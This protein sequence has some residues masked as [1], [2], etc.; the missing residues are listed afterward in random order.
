[1]DQ[2]DGQNFGAGCTAAP[3]SAAA[4]RHA[5]EG[6]DADRRQNNHDLENRAP[7]N[8]SHQS[9]VD[10]AGSSFECP[11]AAISG[12]SSAGK[13]RLLRSANSSLHRLMS[14]GDDS[15][16]LLLQLC[17]HF[18]NDV[19]R[20]ASAERIGRLVLHPGP[21]GERGSFKR[22]IL[23]QSSRGRI[24]CRAGRH[25]S[26]VGFARILIRL[27]NVLHELCLLALSRKNSLAQARTIRLVRLVAHR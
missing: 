2:N 8:R 27:H 16:D 25:V 15:I 21:L 1:M 11:R 7:K 13:I 26:P 3:A 6:N 4:N 19:V 12:A 14:F 23:D 9:S 20:Q 10:P 17:F 22:L 5:C 18:G 24:A